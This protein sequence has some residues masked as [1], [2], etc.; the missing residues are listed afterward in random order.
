MSVEHR[1]FLFAKHLNCVTNRLE[2]YASE[3]TIVHEKCLGKW[4][5]VVC[6]ECKVQTPK[7]WSGHML[8]KVQGA[9]QQQKTVKTFSLENGRKDFR[10][11]GKVLEMQERFKNVGNV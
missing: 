4:E 1:A 2:S 10:N 5:Y 7:N 3:I 8:L 11:A 6:S 9:C